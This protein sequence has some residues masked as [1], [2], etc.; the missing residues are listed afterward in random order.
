MR[1]ESPAPGRAAA[2]VPVFPVNVVPAWADRVLQGPR[3]T[4]RSGSSFAEL[5]MT[6]AVTGRSVPI[7]AGSS[8][9]VSL[10]REG[11]WAR[12]YGLGEMRMREKTALAVLCFRTDD[13]SHQSFVSQAILPPPQDDPEFWLLWGVVAGCRRSTNALKLPSE[14]LRTAWPVSLRGCA[15]H[16][17]NDANSLA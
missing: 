1:S 5:N 12:A 6:Y 16:N 14:T 13:R 4:E 15:S 3:S 10:G 9:F 7:Y 17:S 8:P 2:S 11:I